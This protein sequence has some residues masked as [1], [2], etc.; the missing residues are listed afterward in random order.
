MAFASFGND[1]L[2][3]YSLLF[4]LLHELAHLFVMRKFR[5]EISSIHFYGA[6]IK[7]SSKGVDLLSK[8]KQLLVYSAGCTLNFVFALV[9][10]LIGAQELFAINISLA[11]LN[12]FPIR[13]LDGG[14][15][16]GTLFPRYETI[17]KL[18]SHSFS[19]MCVFCAFA[20]AFFIDISS[21]TSSLFTAFIILVS[22]IFG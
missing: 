17:L 11:T 3:L 18:I 10:L 15:I 9:Y 8:S 6:G 21:L 7:I 19:A 2:I 12:I 1:M 5:V 22:L 16:L 14:K 13:Y 4:C 20:T